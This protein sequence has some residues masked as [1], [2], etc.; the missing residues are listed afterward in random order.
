MDLVDVVSEAFVEILHVLAFLIS[1]VLDGVDAGRRHA[2]ILTLGEREI[3]AAAAARA[4]LDRADHLA[5]AGSALGLRRAARPRDD[6]AVRRIAVRDIVGLGRRRALV[7]RLHAD[8]VPTLLGRSAAAGRATDLGESDVGEIPRRPGWLA[9]SRALKGVER[10]Y[11]CS[12]RSLG[13]AGP[14]PYRHR[15][16]EFHR[17]GRGSELGCARTLR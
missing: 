8:G 3:A 14:T 17:A 12:E 9:D 16:I 2:G 10:A 15:S 11:D 6:D 4:R 1:R 13:T 7:G 5:A